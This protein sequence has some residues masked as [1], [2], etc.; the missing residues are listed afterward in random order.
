MKFKILLLL[1]T[2]NVMG[3][4]VNTHQALTRCATTT[5]C[6][7][8]G[9]KN[10]DRFVSHAEINTNSKYYANEKFEGYEEKYI[11]YVTKGTGLSDWQ[12]K[13]KG[14]YLGMIESGVVLEDAVYPKSDHPGDGRFN[15][16]FYAAQ[17]DS[18]GAYVIVGGV[19]SPLSKPELA[20]IAPA[21]E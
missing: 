2:V 4:E 11:V 6:G 10:L 15:N 20:P 18:K 21:W 9:S 5:E 16:H 1:F 17:F 19:N 13:V 8:E 14:D 3:F 7:R 12:I